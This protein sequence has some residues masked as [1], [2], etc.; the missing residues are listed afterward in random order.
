MTA[1]TNAVVVVAATLVA[2]CAAGTRPSTTR[3]HPDAPPELAALA[4]L[5]GC[6]RVTGESMTAGG[7]WERSPPAAW[8]WRY[9]L[10]GWAIEDQFITHPG[11]GGART[12]GVNVRMYDARAGHWNMAWV[13]NGIDP[14]ATFTGKVVDGEL[15]MEGVYKDRFRTRNV[16]SAITPSSFRWRKELLLP[17]DGGGAAE[18]WVEVARLEARRVRDCE[19][20]S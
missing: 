2:G 11:A 9:I 12:Y 5:I 10:D 7:R 1:P 3:P 13:S 20:C 19:P 15:V 18:R 6:W 17:G 4:P 14:V 8:V 16:F